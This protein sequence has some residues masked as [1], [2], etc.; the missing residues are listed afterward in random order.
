MEKPREQVLIHW[1]HII[2]PGLPRYLTLQ[3][4]GCKHT[5]YLGLFGPK[6]EVLSPSTS[7]YLSTKMAATL[8]GRHIL[9]LINPSHYI[10]LSGPSWPHVVQACLAHNLIVPTN[11]MTQFGAFIPGKDKVK[12]MNKKRISLKLIRNQG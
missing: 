1:L 5:H 8:P 6:P 3:S 4:V 7:L 10:L 12:I 9:T 11:I 2:L